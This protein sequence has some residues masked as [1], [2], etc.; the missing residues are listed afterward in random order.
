MYVP[1]Q[2][3]KN[4]FQQTDNLRKTNAQD[5]L[6]RGQAIRGAAQQGTVA[7]QNENKNVQG[8]TQDVAST[9][10]SFKQE[11]AGGVS[12]IVG[13]GPSA[14]TITPPRGREVTQGMS[15]LVSANA[16]KKGTENYITEGADVSFDDNQAQ[17][18][19]GGQQKQY[20]DQI[21]AYEAGQ[22]AK[23][24]GLSADL[25]EQAKIDI[26]QKEALDKALAEKEAL[27]KSNNYGQLGQESDSDIKNKQFLQLLA[28]QNPS[29][30]GLLSNLYGG[31]MK[32]AALDSNVLES[33]LRQLRQGAGAQIE[34]GK[35]A[36]SVRDQSL[37]DYYSGVRNKQTEAAA[38]YQK[39]QDNIIA[40]R[41]QLDAYKLKIGELTGQA[42]VQAQE[43]INALT[44]QVN[45]LKSDVQTRKKQYDD[46]VKNQAKLQ[47][48]REAEAKAAAERRRKEQ[49]ADAGA[50]G[51]KGDVNRASTTNTGRTAMGTI[52]TIEKAFSG[53]KSSG[54][55]KSSNKEGKS[56]GG[57]EGRSSGGSNKG[58]RSKN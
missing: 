48:Q 14:V 44:K 17:S 30:I 26:A 40:V 11:K 57:G 31:G 22:N 12:Q 58:D 4:F 15:K 33:Q 50:N 37:K 8:K 36:K 3:A 45:D 23:A 46:S 52:D 41:G 34:E 7:Q 47:A 18:F 1:G 28:E 38:N 56:S 32:D 54:E 16:P 55:G 25:G 51:N 10:T 2:K 19:L 42:R 35:T 39:A 29:N 53:N 27:A 9:D 43:Q 49:Q 24:A 6:A 21:A 13:A 20:E 5:A